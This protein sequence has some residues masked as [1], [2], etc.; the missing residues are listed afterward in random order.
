M[1]SVVT[2]SIAASRIEAIVGVAA[3]IIAKP[4]LVDALHLSLSVANQPTLRCC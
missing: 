2:W 4:A 1:A 3:L